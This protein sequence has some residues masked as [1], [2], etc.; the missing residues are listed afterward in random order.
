[1]APGACACHASAWAGALLALACAVVP[2]AAAP[3]TYRVDPTATVARFSVLHLGVIPAHG[4]FAQISGRVVLDAE[5]AA[6]SIDLDIDAASVD[7]GFRLRDAFVRGENMFDAERHPLVRFR[8]TRLVFSGH[9]LA[10]VEG[11]L[12]LRGITRP[13]VL[14]VASLMCAA[15]S[16]GARDSCDAEAH[17][18]ILRREFD[19]DFAWP[20]IGDEV[21]LDFQIRATRE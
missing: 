1:M 2:A 8:S 19:M 11:A 9:R 16:G 12:T 4:R 17:G 20:L 5:A 7:T 15:P 6:G 3:V 18:T 14:T 10:R 21:D 13:V